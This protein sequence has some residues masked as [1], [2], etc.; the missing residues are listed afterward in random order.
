MPF[1]YSPTRSIF[2]F[3]RIKKNGGGYQDRFQ[4]KSILQT[5]EDPEK[6]RTY[7]QGTGFYG[8]TKKLA[9]LL[10]GAVP[11]W[12]KELRESVTDDTGTSIFV[13]YTDYQEDLYQE[14]I[15]TVIANFF[16]AIKDGAL[17]V[18]VGDKMINKDNLVDRFRNCEQILK[19]KQD[20]QDKQDEID[21]NHIK[22]CFQ[23]INT[24]LSAHYDG[25]Q[26]ISGF[27]KVTWYMCIGDDLEKQVGIARNSGM[28]I[29]RKPL[30]FKNFHTK[31]F[32]MFICVKDPEGSEFFKRLENLT[33]N[34]L[35]FDRI[36]KNERGEAKS[37]YRKFVNKIRKIIN[38]YAGL[39]NSDEEGVS[40]LVFLFADISDT[41]TDSGT[42]IERGRHLL[43]KDGSFKRHGSIQTSNGSK[44]GL[45]KPD[46]ALGAGLQGGSGQKKTEGGQNQSSTGITPITGSSSGGDTPKGIPHIVKN[47]RANHNVAK[48]NKAK[49]YFDSPIEGAC[50]LTVS[51]VGENGRQPVKFKHDGEL[52]SGLEIEVVESQ[53]FNIEVEFAERV[54]QLALEATL[55]ERSE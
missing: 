36:S 23:S 41:E 32:D 43:I 54:N 52:V 48:Q 47:F 19:D 22:G 15:I 35:E 17:E 2:Y 37:K 30:N 12:A 51:I 34:K 44:Q 7:T 14:T 53:R 16:Y 45:E 3:S 4:G 18:T 39:D 33:H 42:K 31:R 49:L 9:P 26:Q 55:T 27:G 25:V 1:A 21:T 20:K 40:E 8:H 24:I 29:T 28:L 11:A 6:P 38:S 13:P 5:H 10:D 46:D 50:L